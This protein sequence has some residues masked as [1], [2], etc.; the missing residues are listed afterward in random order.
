MWLLRSLT[1]LLLTCLACA[2][3]AP[4]RAE[5][6]EAE[7]RA[8]AANLQPIK[9]S[10]IAQRASFLF[11]KVLDIWTKSQTGTRGVSLKLGGL[12]VGSGIAGG[13]EYVY[14]AGDVEKPDVLVDGY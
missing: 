13:P 4:T 3:D 10:V 12:A 6:I 8:N 7:R 5:Q 1:P 2:Q 9:E 11:G 14:K